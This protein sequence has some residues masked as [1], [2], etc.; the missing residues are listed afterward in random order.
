MS[1]TFNCY[2]L[3]ASHSLIYSVLNINNFNSIKLRKILQI[4]Q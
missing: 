2:V 3:Q 4:L 1:F